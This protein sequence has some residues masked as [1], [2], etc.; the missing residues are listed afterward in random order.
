M[1]CASDVGEN[2]QERQR[3]LAAGESHE[4]IG[5]SDEIHSNQIHLV[6]HLVISRGLGSAMSC[7]GSLTVS[8]SNVSKG[9]QVVGR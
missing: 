6:I 3:V 8:Y 5:R 1:R 9:S 7:R 4:R 2:V